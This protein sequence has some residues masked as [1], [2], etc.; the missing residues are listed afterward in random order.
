MNISNLDGLTYKIF[1]LHLQILKEILAQEPIDQILTRYSQEIKQINYLE[2]IKESGHLCFDEENRL[3]GAYPVSP[4]ES[5]YLVE[6]EELGSGYGMCAIDALG[7]PFT[8]LK[9]TL[10]KTTDKS[11]GK[12]IEITID[13]N[14]PNQ[15]IL[16]LYVTYQDTPEELQG[17]ESAAFVQCPTINFHSRKTEI[18]DNLQI[19]DFQK[20]LEYSQLRF[21]RNEMLLRIQKVIEMQDN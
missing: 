20:A 13:P 5:D 6:V 1:D 12:K 15:K 2:I 3:V 9:K 11:T 4:I 19:W 8:F 16:D 17:S 10:I 18:P 21:G 7:L 14:N